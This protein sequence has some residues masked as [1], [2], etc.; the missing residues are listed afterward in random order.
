[1]SIPC[2]R[3]SMQPS[4]PETV[5]SALAN[6]PL[7][8]GFLDADVPETTRWLATELAFV[9]S[10]FEEQLAEVP[11]VQAMESGTATLE[12]YQNLLVNLRQQV[13]DGGRWIALTAANMSIELFPIR[14]LLI[15]HAAEEHRDYLIIE[16][17]Y[18]ATG[19]DL[20]TIQS[21]QKNIGSE[22][23]SSFIFHRA[24]LPNPVD[25]F[26]AMFIIEGLGSVKA[27]HWARCLQQYLSLADN[28]VRFLSYHGENDEEHYD[29]L[30]AILSSPM[31]TRPVAAALVRTAKVTAR[32]YALQ[33]AE[34]GNT[35]VPSAS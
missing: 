15:T 9:W 17:D 14:S 27:A 4:T 19:G 31:I 11:I 5:A 22:A 32:L 7:G 6:S 26:G 8:P 29:K 20:A 10:D 16:R 12:D 21:A 2:T 1:M 34:L 30:R 24:S 23:L 25:L 3:P 35:G 13:I 28:Q 18:V 33:L